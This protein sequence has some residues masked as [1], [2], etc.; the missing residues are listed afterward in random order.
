LNLLTALLLTSAL[1]AGDPAPGGGKSPSGGTAAAKSKASAPAPQPKRAGTSGSLDD[2]LFGDLAGD[3][4]GDVDKP[5][6]DSPPTPGKETPK[7]DAKVKK[8]TPGKEPPDKPKTDDA[9]PPEE[10]PAGED[11]GQESNPLLDLGQRMRR[12]ESL[13]SR[14]STGD[15]TQRMQDGIVKDLDKLIKMASQT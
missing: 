7:T 3:V 6:L 8:S 15:P 2:E 9:A 10:F 12:V 11:I 1:A 4:F 14:G 13:I 5:K